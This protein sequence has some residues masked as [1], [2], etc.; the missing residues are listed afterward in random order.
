MRVDH[1]TCNKP[2]LYIWG[3]SH[4]QQS[5]QTPIAVSLFYHHIKFLLLLKNFHVFF[6]LNMLLFSSKKP[7]TLMY[8][9][10]SKGDN[11]WGSTNQIRFSWVEIL[12]ET[13]YCSCPFVSYFRT[14]FW[15]D[16]TI[17]GDENIV[18]FFD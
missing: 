17:I 8:C 13:N 6:F 3:K 15:D 12:Q 5:E 10:T 1:Y 16:V 2:H 14:L 11:G 7:D 4:S 9:K 18:N